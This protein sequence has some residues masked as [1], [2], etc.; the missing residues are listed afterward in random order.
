[1]PARRAISSSPS[2]IRRPSRKTRSWIVPS[3]SSA[4]V[5]SAA[6]TP[7]ALPL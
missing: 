1:M 6:S 5:A 2:R 4:I 7:T 3:S